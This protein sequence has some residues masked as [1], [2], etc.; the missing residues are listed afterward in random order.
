MDIVEQK[1]YH[2]P[3]YA[4]KKK[5]RTVREAQ[6]WGCARSVKTSTG[7]RSRQCNTDRKLVFLFGFHTPHIGSMPLCK[8]KQ[9]SID[10]PPND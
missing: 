6:R 2:V 3:V 7:E 8:A 1:L 5:R 9:R 4:L 10:A